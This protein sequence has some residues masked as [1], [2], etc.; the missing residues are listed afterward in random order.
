MRMRMPDHRC[1]AV[2]VIFLSTRS[3][4]DTAGDA[5]GYAEAAAAM[6]ALAARQ[7]GYVGVDSARGADGFGITVSYWA[8]EAAAVAWRGHP[9]HIVIRDRGRAVWYTDYRVDVAHVTRSYAWR[10]P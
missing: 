7:P 2:A 10:R 6:D 9:D 3:G 5:D 1:G 8:D 4:P